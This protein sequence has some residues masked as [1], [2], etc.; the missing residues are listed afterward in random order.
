MHTLK[1]VQH[2]SADIHTVWDFM[3]RPENL[4]RITPSWL[5]FAIV[6]EVPAAMRDGLLVSYRIRLPFLGAQSWVTEIK[7][8]H[9]PHQFVDEQRLGPYRFWYHHHGF[10][11]FRDGT[12]MVDTVSYLLP[13]GPLGQL[14]HRLIIQKVLEAIFAYR[15]KALDQIFNTRPK[16]PC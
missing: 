5:G 7:H 14:T 10:R 4:D 11:P 3:K 6:S 8:I 13:F 16:T 2:L 1:R 15:F 12:E 9:A